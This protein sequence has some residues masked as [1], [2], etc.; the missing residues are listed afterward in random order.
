MLAAAATF[1]YRTR[2]LSVRGQLLKLLFLLLCSA[3]L[4]RVQQSTVY[5]CAIGTK[6]NLPPGTSGTCKFKNKTK[7]VTAGYSSRIILR[8]SGGVS[9]LLILVG[10]CGFGIVRW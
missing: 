6:S 10:F 3:H 4:M 5:D 1:I 2:R 8:A 9:E 7:K